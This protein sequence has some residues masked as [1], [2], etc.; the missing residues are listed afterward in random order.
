MDHLDLTHSAAGKQ[1]QVIGAHQHHGIVIP[2][3]SLHSDDSYGIGEYLDLI[4]LI[5]W[6]SSVGFDVIQVL[7]L[8][9][10]GF[11]ASPY[12]AI[13]AFALNPLHISLKTLP[14]LNDY[15]ELQNELKVLPKLPRAARID[16][17]KVREGKELFLRHYYQHI[18]DQLTTLPLYQKFKERS[19]N[20][21]PGYALFKTLKVHHHGAG[22]ESWSEDLRHVTHERFQ[23]LVHEHRD[24]IEWH[25][26][27]Q[28]ICDQQLH[29]AKQHA[30]QRG[31]LLMGDIPILISRDSADVWQHRDLFL[32]E[33]SAGSPPDMYSKEGQN[34]G[35]PIYNWDVLAQKG[36]GWWIDRLHLAQRY[37]HLYR[38]DHIVGFFRIWAIPLGK[39]GHEGHFI[40]VD[41]NTWIDHG[42]RIMEMMLQA[43][44]MLPIG[45]DLGV[46]PPEVRQ[47]LSSLGICG[48][49]VMRWERY[50]QGNQ[51]Y[52]PIQDYP[53]E[54]M[55]TVSTHDSETLQLWWQNNF[56]ESQTYAEF[57]GWCYNP[58]LSREHHQEILWASHHSGSLFHINLL[59]EYLALVPGLTWP[60]LEDE[61]INIPGIH[62]YKNWSYRLRPT[63]EEL[64]SQPTLKHLLQEIIV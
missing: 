53:L 26:L 27:L 33:Y 51:E 54:S 13:S 22:W 50:W 49:K 15:P 46:V 24:E 61:R 60:D 9:D 44:T 20:W 17:P 41:S 40:P 2:L 39:L 1:W 12:S 23:S 21:L 43:S 32:L 56:E 4:P 11:E 57:K 14:F 10:P 35:F 28:F 52:I 5:D 47:C 63:I 31:V 19:A 42:L 64:I 18:K 58:K 7:P 30:D 45:E 62:S 48:T 37:Y 38:I 16:Y 3:F 8:N 29:M 59:Q 55:T 6:I 34:W 25:S 36:Y